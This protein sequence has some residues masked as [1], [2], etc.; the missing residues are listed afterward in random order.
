MD[1]DQLIEYASALED[2]SLLD[3]M[4]HDIAQEEGLGTLNNIED[5]DDQESHIS[6]VEEYAS[7]INNGGY[8]TQIDYLLDQGVTIEEIESELRKDQTT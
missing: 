1:R 3:E 7:T 4:V 8:E 2:S 6:C 5:E